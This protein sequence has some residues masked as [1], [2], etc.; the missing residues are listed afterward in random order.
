MERPYRDD[1]QTQVNICLSHAARFS[2]AVRKGNLPFARAAMFTLY[3]AVADLEML[4]EKNDKENA[5]G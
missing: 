4:I 2:T 5:D 1:E 3:D